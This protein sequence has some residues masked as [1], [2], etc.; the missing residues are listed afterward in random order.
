M[1]Q[2]HVPGLLYSPSEGWKDCLG[3]C[4][5]NTSGYPSTAPP[6]TMAPRASEDMNVLLTAHVTWI[7]LAVQN[8][9]ERVA[10]EVYGRFSPLG[11]SSGIAALDPTWFPWKHSHP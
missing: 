5:Q 3:P 6:P 11:K 1:L 8:V 9:P 2:F 10:L 7:C 4:P